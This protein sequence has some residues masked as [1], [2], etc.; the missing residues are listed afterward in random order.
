MQWDPSLSLLLQY[1][2]P[3]SK[4]HMDG[5]SDPLVLFVPANHYKSTDNLLSFNDAD[6]HA[7]VERAALYFMMLSAYRHRTLDTTPPMSSLVVWDVKYQRPG[8]THTTNGFMFFYYTAAE[9]YAIKHQISAL[10]TR[11]GYP[12]ADA[13]DAAKEIFAEWIAGKPFT[14]EHVKRDILPLYAS[15]AQT[16]SLASSSDHRMLND[17][18]GGDDDDEPAAAVSSSSGGGGRRRQRDS[19]E[20][21][22]E[23]PR[24]NKRHRSSGGG[25]EAAAEGEEEEDEEDEEPFPRLGP[26]IVKA[27]RACRRTFEQ[28]SFQTCSVSEFA[29]RKMFTHRWCTNYA[30]DR[31]INYEHKHT[32]D[33]SDTNQ[34]GCMSCQALWSPAFNQ[35]DA[36]NA[37]LYIT[38]VQHFLRLVWPWTCDAEPVECS[39]EV[40]SALGL[41]VSGRGRTDKALEV[42]NMSTILTLDNAL[43]QMRAYLFGKATRGDTDVW[44]AQNDPDGILNPAI[45]RTPCDAFVD[46]ESR[47]YS[48]ITP[49]KCA[50]RGIASQH[51]WEDA[52]VLPPHSCHPL[53][54]AKMGQP[55]KSM[56]PREDDPA[57]RLFC[58]EK[59]ALRR[60][61][62]AAYH[63]TQRNELPGETELE[64]ICKERNE[65]PR[66][67][68]PLSVPNRIREYLEQHDYSDIA[69][70]NA[71]NDIVAAMSVPSGN[72][73]HWGILARALIEFDASTM[74]AAGSG[75]YQS[76]VRNEAF[77][78]LQTNERCVN[79]ALY[80]EHECTPFS[81]VGASMIRTFDEQYHLIYSHS[82]GTLVTLLMMGSVQCFTADSHSS[83]FMVSSTPAA[84]KNFFMECAQRLVMNA[85]FSQINASSALWF[86]GTEHRYGAITIHDEL[87]SV[88][89]PA[90][91]GGGGGS[92]FGG[93]NGGSD[94]SFVRRQIGKF[95]KAMNA[96]QKREDTVAGVN[97]EKWKSILTSSVMTTN[98]M[99]VR[100]GHRV[101]VDAKTANFGAYIVL[102]NYHPSVITDDLQSRIIPINVLQD[103]T[104][105]HQCRTANTVSDASPVPRSESIDHPFRRHSQKLHYLVAMS[106]VLMNCGVMRP[107]KISPAKRIL[108]IAFHNRFRRDYLHL[109]DNIRVIGKGM[110]YMMNTAAT[111]DAVEYVFALGIAAPDFR[112]E[113]SVKN[114][115][116]IEPFLTISPYTACVALDAAD[117]FLEIPL[118]AS[119]ARIVRIHF[120]SVTAIYADVI[121]GT[122]GTSSNNTNSDTCRVAPSA[123]SNLDNQ[124]GVMPFWTAFRGRSI[125]DRGA[126][127]DAYFKQLLETRGFFPSAIVRNF[128]EN[129]FYLRASASSSSSSGGGSGSGG[130]PVVSESEEEQ[131]QHRR[132]VPASPEYTSYVAS[133]YRPQQPPSP[134]RIGRSD[135]V[136]SGAT[137][138]QILDRMN[139]VDPNGS[140]YEIVPKKTR[141][142]QPEM[143][144]SCRLSIVPP[145]A[146]CHYWIVRGFFPPPSDATHFQKSVNVKI[147]ELCATI[148]NCARSGDS[149]TY[150]N[151]KAIAA[152]MLALVDDSGESALINDC[153]VR[154][155]AIRIRDT[156]I[157]FHANFVALHDHTWLDCLVRTVGADA[158]P[159]STVVL[160]KHDSTTPDHRWNKPTIVQLERT[161]AIGSSSSSSSS[162]SAAG[163]EGESGGA[164]AAITAEQEA[165]FRSD[166]ATLWSY[167]VRKNR[168]DAAKSFYESIGEI[169]Q[170]SPKSRKQFERL[171]TLQMCIS[172][173][174][175]VR[176]AYWFMFERSNI[177]HVIR[178]YDKYYPLLSASVGVSS[179]Y[180]GYMADLTW[181]VLNFI[182]AF[183]H[184]QT[185]VDTALAFVRESPSA[186]AASAGSEDAITTH[187]VYTF[188]AE[189]RQ[190]IDE[191][192]RHSL[193]ILR[194]YMDEGTIHHASLKRSCAIEIL[195]NPEIADGRINAEES[196]MP[197]SRPPNVLTDT[198]STFMDIAQYDHRQ[199]IIETERYISSVVAAAADIRKHYAHP[200]ALRVMREAC[201]KRIAIQQT[202]AASV[203][204]GGSSRGGMIRKLVAAIHTEFVAKRE[205]GAS[206]H[207]FP[208]YGTLLS[209]THQCGLG[210][211]NATER[212]DIERRIL[213]AYGRDHQVYG[214]LL[215]QILTDVAA[216]Q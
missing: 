90:Q 170:A 93:T 196:A 100:D 209:I 52:Y 59:E 144:A 81:V 106:H 73:D 138:V 8:H 163:G 205:Y 128:H 206:E 105:D 95:S 29:S 203:P 80:I 120:L 43:K 183:E 201:A 36:K 28:Y 82:L 68:S 187:P 135:G 83:M 11:S 58:Q 185:I 122:L 207:D 50:L 152:A 174:G 146:R 216:H 190:V 182:V 127:N 71:C 22:S 7:L 143:Y 159:K 200:Y 214:D 148:Q 48:V 108:D 117:H 74:R 21:D 101:N 136:V 164:A 156:D 193:D 123:V 94:A 134:S 197:G 66:N 1:N 25:G 172:V 75:G 137:L 179:K 194:T 34:K 171:S 150:P 54:L 155:P 160:A 19:D 20:G 166:M 96:V 67:H 2:R 215:T 27:I 191:V 147:A 102:S 92:S 186:A 184:V 23:P 55:R 5:A 124:N 151:T 60:F 44:H 211:K 103:R 72:D 162:S 53:E 154:M 70:E 113:W 130:L 13:P 119:I 69:I 65:A 26:A 51:C 158:F 3:S 195:G 38:F 140:K 35:F 32:M 17:L 76:F 89:F 10:I 78:E 33:F 91:N 202:I 98:T 188:I 142:T 49:P 104:A 56:R 39:E 97:A 141:I 153:G 37:T 175:K 208:S 107:P 30:V 161:A 12:L 9:E 116:R 46:G 149:G 87:P 84:G 14:M 45:Y 64:F 118:Y 132:S 42:I 145:T 210:G 79:P 199:H 126:Y 110:T 41:V 121:R 178:V 24:R 40:G 4:L 204:T 177:D 114:L 165:E 189:R 57:F 173:R 61:S 6:K 31:D 198:F 115:L 192:R 16:Q 85:C 47:T 86:T 77:W 112:N 168:T 62:T 125:T 213:T 129:S 212:D 63:H 139:L 111:I 176:R 181:C 133:E 18:Y 109:P 169:A 15:S 88:M 180:K 131:Q 157:Q 167:T 99:S